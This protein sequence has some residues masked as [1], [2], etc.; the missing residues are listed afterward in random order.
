[1]TTRRILE[2]C[3]VTLAVAVC[4]GGMWFAGAQT[5][6]APEPAQLTNSLGTSSTSAVWYQSRGS[7]TA[8]FMSSTN[9]TYSSLPVG[10]PCSPTSNRPAGSVLT[11]VV[12]AYGNYRKC[13]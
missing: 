3:A 8:Y 10:T 7:T 11:H 9:W 5:A 13:Q 1:M 12:V 4:A 6:L 2:T